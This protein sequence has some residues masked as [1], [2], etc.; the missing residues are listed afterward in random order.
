MRTRGIFL[1]FEGTEGA[2]K[3]TQ[4][5][6][7][8]QHLATCGNPPLIAR[9][10]GSTP[11]GEQVR[12]WVLESGALPSRSELFL[13]LAA[14]AVFVEEVVQ[15][16]LAAGQIVIADRFELS[17]LAYQGAGRGLPL[18]QIR[19]ANHLAT[20]GVRP[21]ATLLLELSPEEGAQRQAAAGK[22]PDRMEREGV[23]FHERVAAGY[24]ILADRVDGI[25]R[26]DARGTQDAVHARVL[27]VLSVRF[28]ETFAMSGVITCKTPPEES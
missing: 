2:G 5:R 17:T 24:R 15:P 23:E 14:R 19:A 22:L 7:L 1:A 16:A 21:D 11:L 3:T 4:V 10:P 20:G 12:Q 25:L 26:V 18:D 28:P 8:A 13:L 6:R 9:E 27:G